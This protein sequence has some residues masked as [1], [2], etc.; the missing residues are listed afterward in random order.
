MLHSELL[1]M[2]SLQPA[3]FALRDLGCP[4]HYPVATDS[5]FRLVLC[6]IQC[7]WAVWVYLEPIAALLPWE[8]AHSLTFNLCMLNWLDV[9]YLIAVGCK[10]MSRLLGFFVQHWLPHAASICGIWINSANTGGIRCLPPLSVSVLCLPAPSLGLTV[11]HLSHLV[12][13]GLYPGCVLF[14]LSY[15]GLSAVHELVID[16]IGDI[17]AIPSWAVIF[18]I[19]IMAY[20]FSCRFTP[21]N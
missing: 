12:L 17:L 16:P 8:I 5:N 9:W 10:R 13:N 21:I 1:I 2:F 4:S 3:S 20:G 11:R 6:G 15:H 14:C 7:F 18:P 19:D